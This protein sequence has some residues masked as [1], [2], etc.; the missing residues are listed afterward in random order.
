MKKANER[1]LSSSGVRKR[2]AFLLGTFRINQ[3]IHSDNFL[4]LTNHMWLTPWG[5]YLTFLNKCFTLAPQNFSYLSMYKFMMQKI[6]LS[7]SVV[8]ISIT[9]YLAWNL[10]ILL[11]DTVT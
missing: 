7:L 3:I 4:Y 9:I 1:W 11:R 10:I 5:E 6:V 8:C 2:I